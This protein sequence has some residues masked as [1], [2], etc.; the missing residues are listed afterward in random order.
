MKMRVAGIIFDIL[1]EH[2]VKHCFMLSGGGIMYLVDALGQSE[3]AYVSCHHEQSAGI[4]AQAYAMHKNTLGLCIVTTGPGG[5]NA[6]T[7]CAAAYMDSTP[8]LF[9]SGQVKTA[10]LASKRKVRQFGAQENDIISMAAPVTKYAKMVEDPADVLFELQKAIHIALEGRQGPVWLDIPLDV[11]SAEVEFEKLRQY[12]PEP[13]KSIDHLQLSASVAHVLDCLQKARRPLMLLGHGVIAANAQDNCRRIARTLGTPVVSTWRAL[14]V[15]GAEDPLFMGSPGLQ[16]VRSANIITQGAD[17]ILILGSRL[18]NMITAFSEP[19]FAFRAQKVMVD[20]DRQEMA[21]LD[22]PNLS[23]VICHVKDFVE[24]LESALPDSFKG[25]YA[26]WRQFC[27]A[28][29]QRFPLLAE[30][31]NQ[32]LEHADLYQVSAAIGELCAQDDVLVISSTSRCNTAGHM[33]LPRKEGQ[34]S[35]SS[36]GFGSMG[37]ALPSVIG[38]WFASEG[39]RVIM[40]EGDGSL[41]LNIQELQTLVQ[42]NIE[43]KLFIFSNTGYAAIATMQDRN[44]DGRHVGCDPQSGVSMPSLQK[45]AQAYGM[46]YFCIAQNSDI[47][48]TVHAVLERKG[49]V[50]CEVVGD[51]SFDEIPKCISHVNEQGKRVSAVLENPFP[52]LPEEELA[53][54]YSTMPSEK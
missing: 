24:A 15:L 48:E 50:I 51:I 23:P 39:K 7:P 45:I 26:A 27:V 12:T 25:D 35:I 37:F 34:K 8:V 18:D 10:D 9:L 4:A 22:M 52:F 33:A 43:A 44:F 29:K 17:F 13:E 32:K 1:A 53:E 46:A 14:D 40:L 16:A 30:K 11:Q 41:Q 28:T 19:H 6:L 36:M 3:I 20:V 49:C 42:N 31:Q 21:K 47:Q 54:I 38:G 5:T 2:G